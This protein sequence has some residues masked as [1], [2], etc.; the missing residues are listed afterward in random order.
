MGEDW[1]RA[2]CLRGV[3]VLSVLAL[4]SVI[5]PSRSE[6][7][8]GLAFELEL[9]LDDD[10]CRNARVVGAD[11]PERVVAAHPV[12]ADHEIHQRLLERM[13][14]VQRARD[15]RRRQLDAERRSVGPHR[16]AEEPAGFPERIPLRLDGVGFEAFGEFHDASCRPREGLAKATNYTGSAGHFPAA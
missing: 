10:L 2:A 6:I 3:V 1:G 9:L 12:V 14:H 15:I 5:V 8:A 7:V 16:R 13:A 11:L 4:N